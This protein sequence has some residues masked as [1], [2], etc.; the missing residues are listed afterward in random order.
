MTSLS[1]RPMRPPTARDSDDASSS[2]ITWREA[3][4]S[5]LGIDGL[6]DGVALVGDVAR[7]GRQQLGGDALDLVAHLVVVQGQVLGADEV[8]VVVA[9][10]AT[11]LSSRA[12]NCIRPRVCRKPSFSL[13]R[14]TRCLNDGWKG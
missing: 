10:S 7:N 5:S 11:L 3:S 14:A 1:D 8:D 13:N 9:R 12:V 2:V 4:V 6:G